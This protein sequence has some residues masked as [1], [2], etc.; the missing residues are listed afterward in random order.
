M[1]GL[2]NKVSARNECVQPS[3]ELQQL[4]LGAGSG[5]LKLPPHQA[6]TIFCFRVLDLLFQRS[7]FLACKTIFQKEAG[8]PSDR[9]MRLRCRALFAGGEEFFA[10]TQKCP[11][12]QTVCAKCCNTRTT[13]FPG[14]GG[15]GCLL[16]PANNSLIPPFAGF[17]RPALRWNEE[18]P[19][20][21]PEIRA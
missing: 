13:P 21:A 5:A 14:P 7:R 6:G 4:A 18:F 9:I 11:V 16:F 12:P 3:E 2:K 20:C 10:G 1:K 17:R 15:H 8:S 19:A